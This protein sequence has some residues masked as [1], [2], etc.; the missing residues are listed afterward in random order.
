[1]NLGT[2]KTNGFQAGFQ[3]P[4]GDLE[5]ASRDPQHKRKSTPLILSISPTKALNLCSWEDLSQYPNN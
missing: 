4:H 5:E 2:R 3:V 1:M